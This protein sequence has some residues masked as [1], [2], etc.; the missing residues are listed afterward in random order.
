MWGSIDWDFGFVPCTFIGQGFSGPAKSEVPDHVLIGVFGTRKSWMFTPC[1][2]GDSLFTASDNL[3][4]SAVVAMEFQCFCSSAVHVLFRALGLI[5]FIGF[6]AIVTVICVCSCGSLPWFF[7]SFV[8][9]LVGSGDCWSNLWV[10]YFGTF[11]LYSIIHHVYIYIA[12]FLGGWNLPS[13]LFWLIF[14]WHIFSLQ[15]HFLIY[16]IYSLELLST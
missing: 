13:C 4:F 10:K 3:P 5:L 7:C 6:V 16:S 8:I 14:C 2:A 11:Y 15:I 1:Y 9:G 12:F